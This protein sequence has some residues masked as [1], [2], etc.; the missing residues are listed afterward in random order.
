MTVASYKSSMF[1][2]KAARAGLTVEEYLR[3]SERAAEIRRHVGAL[4]KADARNVI[5][6]HAHAH[7]RM[8]FTG[9]V[10]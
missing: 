10:E 5:A 9:G 2:R 1:Q 6:R 3:R 7:G 8:F 4:T